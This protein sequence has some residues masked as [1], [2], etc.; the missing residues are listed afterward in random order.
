MDTHGAMSPLYA[1]IS[2]NVG[3]AGSGGVCAI[4]LMPVRLFIIWGINVQHVNDFP[5]PP[6][7]THIYSAAINSS[8]F[9][10]LPVHCVWQGP[11]LHI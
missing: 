7:S 8:L 6:D 1:L 3:V 10:G 5:L 2:A 11:K 9:V 4:V